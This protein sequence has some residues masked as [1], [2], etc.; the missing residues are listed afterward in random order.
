[1]MKNDNRVESSI[2][3]AF[4]AIISERKESTGLPPY[5]PERKDCGPALRPGCHVSSFGTVVPR[6]AGLLGSAPRFLLTPRP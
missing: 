4:N 5:A 3:I 6:S 1:M 2:Y